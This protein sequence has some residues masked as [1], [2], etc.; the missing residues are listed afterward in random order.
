MEHWKSL[1]IGE[2]EN[3]SKKV[4]E[5][6][7]ECDY[8]SKCPKCGGRF[9]A[10]QTHFSKR[11]N[12]VTR[13]RTC[14]KCEYSIQTAEVDFDDFQRQEVLI[15]SLEKSISEYL[16]KPITLPKIVHKEA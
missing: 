4:K 9:G 3:M 7:T 15:R 11:W 5:D 6:G 2:M 14:I 10:S 1:W 13:K 8:S 16:D 12:I